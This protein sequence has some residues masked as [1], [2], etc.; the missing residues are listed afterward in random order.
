MGRWK[1]KRNLYDPTIGVIQGTGAN[2]GRITLAQGAGHQE[3]I[4]TNWE[5]LAF[6]AW[7]GYQEKG[8]GMLILDEKEIHTY[9]GQFRHV[10][11][12]LAYLGERMPQFPTY[13]D[14]IVSCC[15]HSSRSRPAF[16]SG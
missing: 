11:V 13:P 9:D 5:L 10:G 8:R 1:I 15:W 4:T 3:F 6:H 12:H 7:R 2:P 16:W 14:R